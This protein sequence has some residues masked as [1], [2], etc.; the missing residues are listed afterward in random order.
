MFVNGLSEPCQSRDELII[1]E[2]DHER[3]PTIFING[4]AAHYDQPYASCCPFDVE[5]DQCVGDESLRG[6]G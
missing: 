5:V 3:P 4:A 1:A 2:T 6:V